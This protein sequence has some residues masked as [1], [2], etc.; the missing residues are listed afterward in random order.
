MTLPSF[1][2]L[3]ITG[4]TGVPGYNAFQ[5][6][7]SKY[8]QHVTAIRPVRYWPLQGPGIVP[9]DI[10]DNRGLAA[11]I[12]KKKFNS[13]LHA[14]GTCALKSCE[15]NPKLAYQV[16]VQSIKNVLKM[17]GTRDIRL[18]LLSTDLV[19]PGKSS[20]CYSEEDTVSPV[21]VYGKTM[22]IAEEV[23]LNRYPAAVIFRISLPMGISVNGRAGAIDWIVS[24]FKKDNP[25]TLYYDEVR[26]PFYCEDFNNIVE[27]AL[28]NT[29]RGVYH[30][31]SHRDLSL[32]NIGQIVNKLGGF[33]PHLLQGCMRSEAAT[34]PPRAGNVTMCNRK[35]INALG[36]DPFRNWP[37]HEYHVPSR[38]DWHYDRP[39]HLTFSP[40]QIHKY[41]YTVPVHHSENSLSS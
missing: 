29:M 30:L 10:E 14:A 17:V 23:V 1:L 38:E 21:T 18:I 11:L 27:L 7:R 31:G 6:F 24:R 12:K 20:G 39:T 19:F 34:I 16:N 22:V 37:Y 35:L 26:S 4:L 40:G 25:A 33:S 15:M 13:V 5:Y 2:P 9:L 3:L 36:V 32:Y 8:P 28:G 41:L